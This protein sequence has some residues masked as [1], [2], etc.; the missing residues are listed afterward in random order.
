M[1]GWYFWTVHNANYMIIHVHIWIFWCSNVYVVIFWFPEGVTPSCPLKGVGGGVGGGDNFLFWNGWGLLHDYT[2][3]H[4]K[5]WLQYLFML[6]FFDFRGGGDPPLGTP[7]RGVGGNFFSG[8]GE[9]YYMI[10]HVQIRITGCNISLCC[11]FLILRGG[12]PPPLPL[13]IPLKVGGVIFFSEMREGYYMIIHVKFRIS[14]FVIFFSW[15]ILLRVGAL[16]RFGAPLERKVTLGPGGRT[17]P[18]R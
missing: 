13:M 5:L 8:M 12:Q 10:I 15:A 1:G 4:L 6:W 17:M 14:I 11:D 16:L 9:G 18:K 2:G 3:T 7:W